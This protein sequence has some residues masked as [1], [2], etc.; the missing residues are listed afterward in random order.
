MPQ[1]KIPIDARLAFGAVIGMV[2]VGELGQDAYLGFFLT[3]V[4]FFTLFYAMFRVPLRNS[5]LV[6]IFLA[7]TFPDPT[8]STAVPNFQVPF[9][10]TGAILFAH[11]NAVN[12]KVV[13]GWVSFSLM[14]L[15]IVTLLLV[16]FLRRAGNSK[17]DSANRVATPRP[18]IKLAYV[19]LI[20]TGFA[21]MSG[22]VRGGDVGKSLWQLNRVMYLPI[23]FIL[24][25]LGLRGPKDLGALLRVI[26]ISSVYKSLL[27]AYIALTIK[28]PPNELTGS[29]RPVLA[30]SHQDS[31]LFAV[32]FVTV[33]GLMLERVGGRRWALRLGG[34][35]LPLLALGTWANNRR[36]AWVEVAAVGVT[37][38]LLTSDKNPVKRKIMR[39]MF[40]VIP[41]I[42][43]Y[44]ALGWNRGSKLFKPVQM[45]RSVVD[46][47]SDGSSFWRELENFNLI[48]TLRANPPFGSG[49]GH[50]YLEI[51]KMPE[52]PYDLEFWCP[53]NS[54]L[55][56]WAYTGI[57]GFT[58]LT[59]LW[60]CCVYC[61]VRAYHAAKDP[62]TRAAA[63]VCFGSTLVYL[64]QCWGDLGIGTWIGVW[65]VGPAFAIAGK[66]AVA[67][68]Q[69]NTR[70]VPTEARARVRRP[71][72]ANAA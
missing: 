7:L 42:I 49:Y 56:I 55:G 41:A 69:W 38:F 46:A 72:A 48:Q 71:E 63:L 14:D 15:L 32:G 20:G 30:I 27:A 43:A 70:P 11:L 53:H 54:L 34:L 13:P 3:V 2:L 57:I 51:I 50:G 36:I 28:M 37:V 12:R 25:H 21:W 66:L 35:M 60:V 26:L 22:L 19:S 52:V 61:G 40:V 33:L 65:T 4:A 5:I 1:P 29:T 24:C 8:D 45:M 9:A 67:T 6:L 16:A 18:L 17:L 59:L 58:T 39:S 47:K 62:P 31:I 44:I 10:G 23:I 64:I 68:G